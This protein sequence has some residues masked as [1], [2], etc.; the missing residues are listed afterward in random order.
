MILDL[1][2]GREDGGT[3]RQMLILWKAEG[4][5]IISSSK[6]CTSNPVEISM[7]NMT[8]ELVTSGQKSNPGVH[9]QADA[10]VSV[11]CY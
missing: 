4:F 2:A 1:K 8:L 9:Y 6:R 3:E 7:W 11:K 10:Y 5:I